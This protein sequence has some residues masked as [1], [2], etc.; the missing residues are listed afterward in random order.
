MGARYAQPLIPHR[1]PIPCDHCDG[2]SNGIEFMPGMWSCCVGALL[3]GLTAA[4]LPHEQTIDTAA[5]L[6]K[7]RRQFT[8]LW[9]RAVARKGPT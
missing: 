4:P 5:R 2:T 6:A 3:S 8:A 1:G 9:D 7:R